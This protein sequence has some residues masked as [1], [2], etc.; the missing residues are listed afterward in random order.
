MDVFLVFLVAQPN[1]LIY[2]IPFQG[3]PL[4]DSDKLYHEDILHSYP[5]VAHPERSD[6]AFHE[7]NCPPSQLMHSGW[8]EMALMTMHDARRI[9]HMQQPDAHAESCSEGYLGE[10]HIYP[11][12]GWLWLLLLLS[13]ILALQAPSGSKH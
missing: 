11:R 5:S 9:M 2:F 13:S 4:S 10:Q 3:F 1:T 7:A 12:E 6:Q 8:L